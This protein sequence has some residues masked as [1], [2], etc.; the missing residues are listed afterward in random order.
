[1]IE[2]QQQIIHDN[3][4]AA[5]RGIGADKALNMIRVMLKRRVQ[6]E[7]EAEAGA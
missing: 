2:A 4:N 6:A 3:P 1:M 5:M 7:A